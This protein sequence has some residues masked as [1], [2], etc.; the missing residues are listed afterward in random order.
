MQDNRIEYF[1]YCV[2]LENQNGFH[3]L[4]QESFILPQGFQK[5][6]LFFKLHMMMKKSH[7]LSQNTIQIV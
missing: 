2:R 7:G 3:I 4:K 6:A 1:L 5:M